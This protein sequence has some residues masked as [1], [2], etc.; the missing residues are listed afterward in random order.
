MGDVQR[1]DLITAQ[2][3][4]GEERELRALGGTVAG[5]DFAVVWACSLTE[6]AAAEAEGREAEGI[7]WPAEDVRVVDR[8][9]A[10]A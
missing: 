9:P 7:P 6:W 8:E 10:T 3:A 1:G 2:G 4:D 5:G